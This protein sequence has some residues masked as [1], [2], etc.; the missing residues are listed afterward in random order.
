MGLLSPASLAWLALLAPLVALYVL[1]RKHQLRVVGSTLLWERAV[2]DL[3]A[4]RP[5]QRLIPYASLLLQAS[6]LILAALALARPSGVGRLPDGARVVVVV[7]TS[8]SMA[9]RSG[10]GRSTR[11]DDARDAIRALAEALP[12]GGTL[13]LV[14]ASDEPTVSLAPTRDPAEI[15]RAIAALEVRGVGASIEQAVALAQERLRDAPSG[16]R[17]VVFTDGGT[18]EATTLR[19]EVPIEVHRVGTEVPNDA[20]VA[21]DV[22][23][24]P[25]DDHPDR[26]EIFARVVRFADAPAAR[27][28]V[29]SLEGGG[30]LA[31]RR[32]ELEPR[33]PLGVTM[34]ADLPPDAEG[35]PGFVRVT[36]SRDDPAGAADALALDDVAI[37]PSPAASR[38]PVFLVGDAPASLRRALLADRDVEPYRTTLEA[39]AARAAE[40]PDLELDGL[41]IYTGRAPDAP[42]RGDA[43]VVAPTTDRVFG[44]ALGASE[45]GARIVS[46]RSDDPRLRFVSLSDVALDSMRPIRGGEARALVETDRGVAAAS[47][48]HPSG[49]VTLLG[50]DPD[51]S[52][53][54]ERPSFVILVRNL[55]ERAR[56]HRAEGGI[57]SARLGVPLRVVAPEGTEID[58]RAP[59]GGRSRTR[60]RSGV[61]LVTIPAISGAFE[62]RVGARR[63]V[64]L[65][66]LLSAEESDPRARA[67]FITQGGEGADVA[68]QAAATREAWV[69]VA[70]ALLLVL[71]LEALWATR[72]G[73]T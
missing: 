48:T 29:A 11:I 12:S 69:Y 28:I 21:L 3:R 18:D 35:R 7:D 30:V 47:L 23:A 15:R 17:I 64:G 63:L 31:S 61:S 51:R 44:V 54:P 59:D 6:A 33:E 14:E 45:E 1:R 19:A 37:A 24:R 36:L 10:D 38:L 32:V 41:V 72:R 5:F 4:E 42:P 68:G 9:I 56:A 70:L 65:R 58:V 34:L 40:A 39:I 13:S 53:L 50:F 25:S 71:A 67:R 8:A 16:S 49:E 52:T 60:A 2:R 20:I 27:W 73:A 22:R 43:L 46:W 66:N 62:V 55:V 57:P 26:A